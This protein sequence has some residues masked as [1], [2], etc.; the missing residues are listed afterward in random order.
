MMDHAIRERRGDVNKCF[1]ATH[2]LRQL[3]HEERATSV[4]VQSHM[5]W[6]IK[7]H[8]GSTV[9]YDLHQFT[10]SFRSSTLIPKSGNHNP[11]LWQ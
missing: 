10:N 6:L 5:E 2:L 1:Q 8:S 7:L 4:D 11:Q 3:H 9:K